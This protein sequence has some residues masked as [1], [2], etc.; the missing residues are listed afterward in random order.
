MWAH[1]DPEKR[2]FCSLSEVSF[3][4]LEY[5]AEGDM[6]HTCIRCGADLVPGE[7]TTQNQIDRSNYRCRTCEREDRRE[8]QRNYQ[9]KHREHIRDYH[10]DRL[11]RIGHCKPMS[12]NRTCPAFLGVFVAERVLSH[13]FKDVQRMPFGNPGFDFRCRYGYTIDVKG[14]CRYHSGKYADQW[15]FHI[16]QNKV[17]DY[18]LCLAF[19]NRDDLNPE[20]IWLIPG[21]EINERKTVGISETTLEKWAQYEQ[22]INKVMSCCNEM[23]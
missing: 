1:M 6:M 10:R 2:D 11:H 4:I 17:A 18:F 15:H 9:Q 19:D 22:P 5:T 20:H 7:N 13:V 23:R 3:T 8:Y 21:N 12:E 16:R 14:S